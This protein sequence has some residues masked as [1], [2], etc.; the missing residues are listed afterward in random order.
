MLFT[1]RTKENVAINV[2][3]QERQCDVKT[4]SAMD[5]EFRKEDWTLP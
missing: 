5:D 3:R 2:V 1:R 4:K